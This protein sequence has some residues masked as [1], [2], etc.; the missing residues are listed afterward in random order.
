MHPDDP[1]QLHMG[2]TTTVVVLLMLWN[3]PEP[4]CDISNYE[5]A[6]EN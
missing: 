2:G 3:F 4:T 1:F 5:I 6:W